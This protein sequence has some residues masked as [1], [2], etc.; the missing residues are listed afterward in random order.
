M[1]EE[2]DRYLV[3]TESRREVLSNPYTRTRER[4]VERVILRYLLQER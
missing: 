4:V 1:S 3:Q 2:Y